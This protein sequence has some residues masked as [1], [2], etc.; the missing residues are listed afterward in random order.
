M[1]KLKKPEMEE[2]KP[3]TGEGEGSLQ[4][5]LKKVLGERYKSMNPEEEEGE[6][7]EEWNPWD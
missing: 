6:E 7:E 1:G 2:K 4:E 3:E 5:R